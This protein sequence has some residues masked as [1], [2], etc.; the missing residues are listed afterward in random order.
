MKQEK[1]NDHISKGDPPLR[2]L[3]LKPEGSFEKNCRSEITKIYFPPRPR[4]KRVPEQRNSPQPIT[5]KLWITNRIVE[6]LL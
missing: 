6:R 5:S 4:K 1:I 2:K 3:K